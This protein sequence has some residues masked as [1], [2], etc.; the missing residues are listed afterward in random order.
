M[1]KFE[2]LEKLQKLKEDGIIT[3][4]EFD[5]EKAKILNS[6]TNIN[7]NSSVNNNNK[8]IDDM[9]EIKGNFPLAKS[10]IQIELLENEKVIVQDEAVT[11]T[12][13]ATTAVNG[14]ITLTTKRILFNKK[15]STKSFLGTGLL[16]VALAAGNKDVSIKFAQIEKI[17]AKKIRTTDGIEIITSDGYSHKFLFNKS[18]V[19]IR[20]MIIEL[21]QGVI[22]VG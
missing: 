18:K 9:L 4:E 8:D 14:L 3:Q 7:G 22:N 21:I 13:V 5:T 2:E 10:K 15:T 16:G 20:D 1:V 6:D 11:L 17:E 19:A 12:G